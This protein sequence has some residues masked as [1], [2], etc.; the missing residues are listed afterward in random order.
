[1]AALLCSSFGNLCNDCC[2]LVTLPCRA[3]CD[4]ACSPFV[5]YIAVTLLLNVPL[6]V[7]GVQTFSENAAGCDKVWWL[8]GNAIMA[9]IHI[10]ASLYIS[11]RIQ[12]EKDF[13]A[14]T[15]K[16]DHYQS[17]GRYD[18]EQPKTDAVYQPAKAIPVA[19]AVTGVA[20]VPGSNPF[21]DLY[22][23]VSASSATHNNKEGT[24]VVDDAQQHYEQPIKVETLV[25]TPQQPQQQYQQHYVAD[26]DGEVMTCHRLSTV[27]C[28]DGGVAVYILVVIVWI[29]WQTIG[30]SSLI[31]LA[32]AG[33]EDGDACGQIKKWI[34]LSIMCGWAYMMVV[35]CAFGCS[36][37]C[38][39]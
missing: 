1:M 36:L 19:Q 8:W 21:L 11:N 13:P 12:H 20:P 16:N 6:V 3:C 38:L 17:H 34:V 4:L 29:I 39:R 25:A 10:A 7:W 26:E 24:I 2:S 27:M 32:A 37:I 31:A 35:F 18:A 30:V 22:N 28:Y 5:P 14:P 23:K 9:A 15:N 33:E